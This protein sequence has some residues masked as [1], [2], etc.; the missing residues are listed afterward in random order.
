MSDTGHIS[1]LYLFAK[2]TDATETLRGYKYQELKTLEIWLFNK[3]NGIDEYIY[4]D[5]E[6]DIFQ[7]DLKD[8][9]TTFKQVKLYSSRNFSLSSP[10]LIK[11]INHFFML[12]IK[13]EYLFDEPLF[14][15]ETN[16]SYTSTRGDDDPNLLKDWYENQPNIAG[17]LLN[18]CVRKLKLIIED[19]IEQQ[20]NKIKSEQ[21]SSDEITNAKEIFQK[22]PIETWEQFAKSI[23][24][25]F[26]GISTDEAIEESIKYSLNLIKQLKFPIDSDEYTI[27][28][29]RLRGIISDKSMALDPQDKLITNEILDHALLSL[30]DKEDKDY[31]KTYEIWKDVA[32]LKYFK[33]AEFYQVLFSAK[34]CR[35]KKYLAGHSSLWIGLLEKLIILASPIPNCRRQVIYELI[36]S[37]IRPSINIVPT[38]SL[39]GFE[40]LVTGY[41]HDFE[42]YDDVNSIGDTLNLLTI[43]ATSQRL[44]LISIGEKEIIDWFDRFDKLVIRCKGVAADRNVY[45][46]LLE[47]EGFVFFTKNNLGI[48]ENNLENSLKR[49]EE[50]IPLLPEAKSYPVSQFGK[51]LDGIIDIAIKI[52]LDKDLES[53]EVFSE[54]LHPYIKEREGNFSLAKRYKDRGM[55]YLHSQNPRG[56]LKALDQFHKAKDLYFDEATYEGFVLALMAISQLYS[57]VG[58]NLASKY[59]SLSAIWFCSH[60]NDPKLYKRISDSSGLLFYSDF[61]QGTW[62]SA[63]SDF[64][65]YISV[66][67]E[68]DPTEFDPDVDD[69]L[70]KS[71]ADASFIVALAPLISNQLT[72]LIDFEKSKMGQLYL[73]YIKV[74]V[75]YLES[76]V[77]KIGLIDVASRRL[78]SPPINDIGENRIISW[79]CFGSIW[80]IQ[81]KNDF[82]TN[83]VGEE[84][85]ALIQ[86]IQSDI[87][88]S[89][90]DFHLTR[91]SIRLIVEI[92]D[93]PKSPEQLPSK[94]EYQWKVFI[95]NLQSK[96][97]ADKNLHYAFISASFQV[98]LNEISLLK[99]EIFQE[100]FEMLYKAGLANKT[101][102]INAYQREYREIFSEE[103]FTASMRNKFNSEL[104]SIDYYES[105]TFSWLEHETEFYKK[106]E[107]IENIKGRYNNCLK[108]IPITLDELKKSQE[109]SEKIINLRRKGWLDWQILMALFNTIINLKA[110]NIL[111]QN[112]EKYMSDQE[113]VEDLQKTISEIMWLDE[114]ETYVE[115]P[116]YIIYGENFDLQIQL[117]PIHVLES[118]GLESKSRFPNSNALKEFL[119]ERFWFNTDDIMEL[120]PFGV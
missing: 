100:R 111:R 20:A 37:K 48:G 114:E 4:C 70:F 30:G 21:I 113:W 39:E 61:K 24:W 91:G 97:S 45:C 64:E 77:A 9:K 115:I 89:G 12:F 1:K 18:R 42:R 47:I 57:S 85:V 75:E 88:L 86:I 13:G 58:M 53:F 59:Y 94:D 78:D 92:V 72:G 32:D 109:F 99:H 27:V 102:A 25:I 8:F 104:L 28:F 60:N 31:L 26:K 46:N 106:K 49:F 44:G 23:R 56:L 81:F 51:T 19:Y 116:L 95:Q 35:K 117:L 66:R 34:Y 15:F 36:W 67:T 16:T 84:F 112:G 50:I 110:Q 107:A 98:V 93:S 105:S 7:R 10:E 103:K 80:N 71:I 2:D 108:A 79:K 120:S 5:Y 17:D 73:D 118:F 74:G 76:E 29:D 87:A 11:A 52:G 90:I 6:E 96:E 22:V 40:E 82:I 83:S 54:K 38:S 69:M 3:V 41:F 33:I 43:V 55:K 65:R 14:I 101:L 119:N 68:L 62:I 63:L